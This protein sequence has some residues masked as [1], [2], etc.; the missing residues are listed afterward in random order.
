M[1]AALASCAVTT[2]AIKS[3][4]EGIPFP[5]ASA[6]VVKE[7]TTTPPRKI[8]SLALEV[9]LPATGHTPEQRARLEEIGR[10]CPVALSLHPAVHVAMTFTY[11][12]P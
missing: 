11:D 3:E 4:A 12:L 7:M 5:A 9:R 1:G 10:T 6:R 8:A 2:M